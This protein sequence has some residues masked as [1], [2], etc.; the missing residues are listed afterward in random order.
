MYTITSLATDVDVD[1]GAPS[2]PWLCAE[3]G[4][5]R[6]VE[7]ESIA[8]WVTGRLQV[9]FE[10]SWTQA[11]G[12]AFGAPAANVACRQLGY[13]AG[14]VVPQDL[15]DT[16]L[17]ALRATGVVPQIAIS[18]SGCVGTEERLVDCSS[19]RPDP[20]FFF[21]RD[22]LSF[23]SVGLMLG[24]V[25]APA[26]GEHLAKTSDRFHPSVNASIR[27]AVCITRVLLH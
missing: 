13:G 7:E 24:C 1:L 3:E 25:A 10:G 16:E 5:L 4:D 15:T 21:R 2:A 23:N 26:T 9:F 12:V 17:A 27:G 18:G 20:D 6:L 19:E 11:C 8:N 22:C 14:T